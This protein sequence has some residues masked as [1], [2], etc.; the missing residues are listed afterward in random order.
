MILS[1]TKHGSILKYEFDLSYLSIY[2]FILLQ[3]LDEE[4][5]IYENNI[6]DFSF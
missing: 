4:Q 5:F 6:W 2:L 1:N 3:T